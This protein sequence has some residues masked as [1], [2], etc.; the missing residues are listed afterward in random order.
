M[1]NRT[2]KTVG[3]YEIIELIGS[4]ACGDV[5]KGYD[6]ILKRVVA[7]KMPSS[8]LEGKELDELLADFFHA[9]EVG[10]QFQHANIVTVYDIGR[11]TPG[12]SDEID[13]KSY[14]L[15]MEYVP[16]VN[17][18]EYMRQSPRL[19]IEESL[20]IVFECCKALDY[21]HFNG[22][23][24]RDIKPGNIMINTEN[25]A[26]KITDFSISDT[27]YSELN[28]HMGTLPYMTP[29]HFLADTR[30]T[31]QTDIF[32]L[33]SV[34]YH[35]LSGSCPFHGD[36]VEEVVKQITHS[37]PEPIRSFNPDVPM[38]VEFI[39]IKAM[40]KS[41]KDR[42]QTALEFTDAVNM[43]LQTY[44]SDVG[45]KGDAGYKDLSI[46]EYLL[47]RN[48]SWFM[49]FSPSD[50]E[51]LLRS[52]EI[53]YF[54]IDE[55]IVKEGEEAL[56]FY[57]LLEGEADV[58]KDSRVV[59]KLL[60]GECFGE[61]GHLTKDKKRTASIRASTPVRV[62]SINSEAIAELS[63]K[64]QATLYKAFLTKTLERLVKSSNKDN[65][66]L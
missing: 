47:L 50:I 29:E 53:S 12:S 54:D 9:A 45:E 52:G 7:I 26:V 15:V 60:T 62:L 28:K 61:I 39:V 32:A 37:S 16:G 17:L 4:G 11:N 59:S 23:A 20:R 63:S 22:I 1:K 24:H 8:N 64:S 38:Q 19:P 21:I 27:A 65:T 55:Y 57:T 13:D 42:F 14:Y 46:E 66:D 25:M 41:P 18:L 31:Q 10:A 30:L 3:R 35:L 44:V 56:C 43:A 5:F 34:M 40:S 33:G 48:H 36:S 49:D 51:E 2:P 6:P 58:V